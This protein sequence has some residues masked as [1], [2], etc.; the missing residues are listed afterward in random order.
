MALSGYYKGGISDMR[1]K[2]S[3]I[4]DESAYRV[5]GVTATSNTTDTPSKVLQPKSNTRHG[6]HKDGYMKAYR[7][8]KRKPKSCP[9][10]KH[11]LP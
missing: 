5:T 2:L 4:I 1:K 10:C 6:R 7:A 3:N 9:Y 11:E 8:K